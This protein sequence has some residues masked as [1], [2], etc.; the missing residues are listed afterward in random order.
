MPRCFW[1]SMPSQITTALSTSMPMAMISAPR[2]MRSS[3]IPASHIS[4]SVPS[5]VRNS[6]APMITPARR[7][8]ARQSTPMT[9]AT[10]RKTLS[11]K[12]LTESLTMRCCW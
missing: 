2:E 10:E 9:M 8:I 1:I 12:L 4:S 11:A 5:T 3:S 6:T 7:P